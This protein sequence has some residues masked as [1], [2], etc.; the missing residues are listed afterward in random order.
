MIADYRIIVK[1]AMITY[2]FYSPIIL[3]IPQENGEVT[4]KIQNWAGDDI[5]EFPITQGMAEKIET[6]LMFGKKLIVVDVK[7]K[8]VTIR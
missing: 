6:G 7:G 3:L 5:Y 8:E 4:L 1:N 2:A